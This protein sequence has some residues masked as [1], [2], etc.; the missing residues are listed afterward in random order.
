MRYGGGPTIRITAVY[1]DT[2]LGALY[3]SPGAGCRN[4]GKVIVA[5]WYRSRRR[6]LSP[7]AAQSHTGLDTL[8]KMCFHRV[9]FISNGLPQTRCSV[10]DIHR[11]SGSP[12]LVFSYVDYAGRASR[13]FLSSIE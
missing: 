10:K 9:S 6:R 1:R 2:S 11:A 12:G 7:T 4:G 5:S 8:D 3:F 13:D